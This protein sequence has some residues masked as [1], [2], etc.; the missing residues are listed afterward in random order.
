MNDMMKELERIERLT[1]GYRAKRAPKENKLT[2]TMNPGTPMTCKEFDAG[3]NRDGEMVKFCVADFV[4]TAGYILSWRETQKVIIGSFGDVWPQG[5]PRRRQ[6]TAT[7]SRAV[8]L[9]IAESRAT[10]FKARVAKL[11]AAR[12]AKKGGVK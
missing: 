6:F 8:A 1:E 11:K 4:N 10:K 12:D 3:L 9:R 5:Q 2:L 7:K